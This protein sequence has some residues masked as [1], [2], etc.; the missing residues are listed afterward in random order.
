MP[1]QAVEIC[2]HYGTPQK[3]D[4]TECGN[5][6]GISLVAHAAKILLKIIARRLSEYCERVGILPEEQSGFRPNRS[7]T[8]MMF[9]IRR[10]QELARK[11]RIPLYVCFIDLT[12]AYESVDRTL[13]WTVLAR[14]GVPH[15][16]ISVI[17]QFHDGMRACVRLDDRMWS[18]W[19]AV[20]HGLRQG[21]ALAPLLF[22]IF[23]AAV[24]NVTFT[25]FKADKG[26]MDALVHPG[27]KRGAG[28]RGQATAGESV[29]AT[30]LWG[31]LYADD[32][33]VVSQS[34][35]QLRQMMGVIVVVCAAF[36]LTV[37]E[38]KTAIMC[39]RAKG[40]RSL[41]PHSA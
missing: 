35:E 14:F 10:L 13:L 15:N 11:K 16:M 39:L 6:T 32:A 34:P 1:Q 21:C 2:H 5:Y 38:A 7:T 24:V 29:L 8:D 22:N 28:G 36:G 27:K 37:S 18:G 12:K 33:G 19:F 40:C 3:K 17:R 4:R 9:E 26:I 25:R 20:E 41:P 30:P 23:F 31:M